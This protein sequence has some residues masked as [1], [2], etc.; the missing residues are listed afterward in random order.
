MEKYYPALREIVSTYDT[1][2][3]RN[4]YIVPFLFI[5]AAIAL[6]FPPAGIPFFI[7]FCYM[8]WSWYR[9]GH[10]LCPRCNKPFFPW[11]QRGIVPVTSNSRF[12]V[13]KKCELKVCELPEIECPQNSASHK[14]EWL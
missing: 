14:K 4:K 3:K 10:Y 8:Y 7:L 11:L 1:L 9:Y 2:K 6:V 12:W 5:G 13:C